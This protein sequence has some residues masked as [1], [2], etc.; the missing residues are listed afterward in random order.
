MGPGNGYEKLNHI[1]RWSDR[2]LFLYAVIHG[3]LGIQNHLQYNHPI[4]GEYE[5]VL[6]AAG[7]T[8]ILGLLDDLVRRIVRHRRGRAASANLPGPSVP[9]AS[10]FGLSYP[11]VLYLTM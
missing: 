4:L 7:V 6:L 11:R 5:N 9:M 10:S 1:Y 8:F 3:S 2:G